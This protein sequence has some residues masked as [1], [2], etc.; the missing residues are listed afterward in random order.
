M[1]IFDFHTH[2]YPSIKWPKPA[3][4]VRRALQNA[5]RPVIKQ[6]HDWAWTL[7]EAP[8]YLKRP[9]QEIAPN[10]L[11]SHLF[12]EGSAE[13]LKSAMDK[14]HVDGALVVAHPPVITN[15]FV[16]ETCGAE[17][18]L[19]S[20][21]QFPAG[22]SQDVD[23]FINEMKNAK[24]GVLKIHPMADGKGPGDQSY[25]N[26]LEAAQAEGMVVVLHTGVFHSH[27]LFRK[28]ELGNFRLYKKWFEEF[29]KV[30]FVIAHFNLFNPDDLLQED[31]W[32]GNVF[33][34]TS[35][36]RPSTLAKAVKKLSSHRL[37]FSSDWPLIGENMSVQLERWQT[38]FDQI[39]MKSSEQAAI[40]GGN[41]RDLLLDC[42]A[43]KGAW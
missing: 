14:N 27:L 24:V 18:S 40:L 5:W 12:L 9:I 33:F 36:Q 4:R 32:A 8:S 11:I 16:Y 15:R 19:A 28:P 43:W 42:G 2:A 29:P 41:A 23:S 26:L 3:A 7:S 25:L 21:W 34:S 17:P 20:A 22:S 30:Q 13:D 1:R 10:L 37:L 31:E 38:V 39:Q 6:S 35:W